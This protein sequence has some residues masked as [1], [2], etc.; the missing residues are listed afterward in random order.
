PLSVFYQ[1]WDRPLYTV[2]AGQIISDALAGY[3]ARSGVA[4]LSLPAP[5]GSVG[6]A[7]R[8]DPQNRRATEEAQVE[9]WRTWRGA[10][11]RLWLVDDKGLERPS[12][13]MIEARAR[14]CELIAPDR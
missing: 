8:G 1:V 10:G 11:G 12:G 3:R 14:L 4:D 9:D 13:Q 7:L 6:A 5:Q 2:G